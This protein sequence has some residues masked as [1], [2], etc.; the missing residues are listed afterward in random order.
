MSTGASAPSPGGLQGSR[1]RKSKVSRFL[2]HILH[3]HDPPRPQTVSQITEKLTVDKKYK[4][5][6]SM[7][8]LRFGRQESARDNENKR[9]RDRNVEPASTWH[10]GQASPPSGKEP[11]YTLG[12]ATHNFGKPCETC[13]TAVARRMYA[14]LRT[15][16]ALPTT[17]R[18]REC[19]RG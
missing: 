5:L 3:K 16:V 18:V 11:A 19:A 15:F 17:L 1:D 14:I 6:P 4:T 10:A 12:L 9:P 7:I 13:G 2:D 8:R